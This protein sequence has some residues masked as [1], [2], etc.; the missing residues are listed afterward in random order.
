MVSAEG[1]RKGAAKQTQVCSPLDS[2]LRG[3]EKTTWQ[4]PEQTTKK[5]KPFE[6]ITN[7]NMV[8]RLR[9]HEKHPCEGTTMTWW[10]FCKL[11]LRRTGN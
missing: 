5:E 9:G 4:P 10:D 1:M 8:I 3:R 11:P 7:A 6:R 2:P